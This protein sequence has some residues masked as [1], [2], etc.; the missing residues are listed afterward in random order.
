MKKIAIYL[1]IVLIITI[2]V[3][4]V[5]VKTFSFVPISNTAEGQSIDKKYTIRP[6]VKDEPIVVE[7]KQIERIK[8]YNTG[9]KKVESLALD[10]YVKGVVAAEMPAAFHIEALKAQAIAARTYAISRSIRFEN[11]HP[12]H[13]DAPLCSKEHC[14]A[15]LSLDD[16]GKI[17]GEKWIEDY[18]AKIE[19]AVESTSN[20]VIYY[21]GEIIE[22]LYHST[23]GGMTEDA[24]NVFSVDSPY[25]KAVNS[26][27][28][29][30][31]PRYRTVVNLTADEFINKLK[32]KY[33]NIK[34]N[35]ENFH[36]KIKLVEKTDSGRVK[37]IAIDGEMIN[38]RDIRDLY[39]LNSTNFK[40]IFDKKLN[41]IEI[42][43]Y[44]YGHGVGM[45]QWGANGMGK[46]GKSYEEILKHYYTG[47]DI[48]KM[49]KEK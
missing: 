44:G 9:T 12:D 7:E 13:P 41:L 30:D 28:E 22:P 46:E 23:S 5:I 26:P 10:E 11:G 1:T 20:L 6:V 34:I 37:K 33:S 42:E 19:E 2:F 17:H 21:E 16:L 18:W 32:S 36:E 8:V 31:A 29:Q 47:I 14:Q 35:K 45:S 25:L 24:I 4:T 48:I 39:G 3:P 43:T 40:I 49:S 38:G 27:N 15:Y